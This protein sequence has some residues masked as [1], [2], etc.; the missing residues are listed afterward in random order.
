MSRLLIIM[1]SIFATSGTAQTLSER[2]E[3]EMAELQH[4]LKHIIKDTAK[5]QEFK[6]FKERQQRWDQIGRSVN[7]L[8]SMVEVLDVTPEPIPVP[9]VYKYDV[10]VL[11]KKYGISFEDFVYVDHHVELVPL[12]S[13]PGGVIVSEFHYTKDIWKWK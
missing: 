13:E 10:E 2:Y 1:F 6:A 3:C 5:L 11:K 9:E 7:Y 4:N 12:F 8:T